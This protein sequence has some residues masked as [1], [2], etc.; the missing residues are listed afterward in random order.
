MGYWHRLLQTFHPHPQHRNVSCVGFLQM[1]N[2]N[3]SDS[4]SQLRD[5]YLGGLLE[6]RAHRI[7][8]GSVVEGRL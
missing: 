4:G 7:H 8:M 5:D 3:S 1:C 6:L 2:Y